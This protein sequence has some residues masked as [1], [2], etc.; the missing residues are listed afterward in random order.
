MPQQYSSLLLKHR[1]HRL[2]LL[3]KCSSDF[4]IKFKTA[5]SKRGRE[6]VFFFLSCLFVLRK[7]KNKEE[8][9]KKALDLI[10]SVFCF[11]GYTCRK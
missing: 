9:K 5:E 4:L 2:L 8:E 6:E 10:S 1:T 11:R 3:V 7:K